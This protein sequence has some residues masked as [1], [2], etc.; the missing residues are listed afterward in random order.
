MHSTSAVFAEVAVSRITGE[1]R[2]RRLLGSF[3]CGRII[4]AKTAASQFRGGMIMG[5][6][7]ALTEKTLF[8][9]RT[10]RIMNPSLAEYHVPVH[11]DV[12]KIDV[13]WTDIPDPHSPMGARGIGEIG[14]TGTGAAIANAIYNATGKRIR[15]LPITLD[16]LM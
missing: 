15:E 4:N 10:G 9:E 13:I 3:D 12:P 7:L 14:I 8:D 5:L 6:G 16:K 2:V 1:P 11:L